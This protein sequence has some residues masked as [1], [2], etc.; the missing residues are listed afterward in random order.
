[1]LSHLSD[2]FLIR[3][4]IAGIGFTFIAGPLGCFIVWQR[5]TYLGEAMAHSA[6]LG[7]ALALVLDINLM[8]GVFSICL[9]IALIL[10]RVNTYSNLSG[11]STLGI[12]SHSTL[13]IGLVLVSLMY[14]VRV[15]ILDFLFGN[16]ILVSWREIAIIYVG[17]GLALG[18]LCWKWNAL[19]GMTV[20][21]QI[22][23]A[24]GLNPFQT[25]GLLMILLAT[26]IAF[27]MKV[28]GIILTIALLIIPAATA[29]Q[30]ANTPEQM[31]Y[32]ATA[33]GA[34]AVIGGLLMSLEVDSPPGPSIVVFATS[35]FLLITLV[36]LVRLR[37]QS[38]N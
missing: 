25:R 21:E 38:R 1:M 27:A 29:R 7:I 10:S 11:D 20:N 18:V 26:T 36:R 32:L 17:S 12:L 24:E 34:C 3:A 37:L 14:W 4:I 15:D 13:A 6:L 5:L 2:E 33:I 8:F 35:L 9:M 28:V 30:L 23:A 31:A 22:A 16:I 19:I